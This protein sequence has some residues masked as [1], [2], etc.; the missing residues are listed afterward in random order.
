MENTS[1]FQE[2][3]LMLDKDSLK[4]SKEEEIIRKFSF[5]MKKCKFYKVL[6]TSNTLT[7][8]ST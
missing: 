5:Y 8:D 4:I 1:L 7:I 2:K 6:I 3:P